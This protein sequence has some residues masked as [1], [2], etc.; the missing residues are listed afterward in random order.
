MNKSRII[1]LAITLGASACGGA[2]GTQ[3][4]DMS[5][6]QHQAAA[7][8]EEGQ[9]TEHA[10]QYDPAAEQTKERCAKGRVCWTVASNA[11]EGHAKTA[12]EHQ[13]LAAKHRLA[14]QAL[15]DAEARACNGIDETDRDVSPF[16]RSADI[17]SV[18]QLREETQ[19]GRN[20]V[21]RD[22]GATIVFRA[23]P[24][25]TVEWLQRIVDCHLARNAAVGHDMPEMEYCPVVTP[26]AQ[27][28]VRSVGDG[29]AV[30]VRADDA[31]SAQE[32]WRRAQQISSAR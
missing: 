8:R 16:A 6:A 7:E 1:T 32:I 21:A 17:R 15:R 4:H 30:D 19:V 27:A 13:E 10:A 11:T 26:G 23:T 22:A 24:G 29:F 25:L 28:K 5:A 12:E 14:S 2:A 9:A 31:E 20:K 3:P 18:S